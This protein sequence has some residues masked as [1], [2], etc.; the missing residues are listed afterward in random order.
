[1]PRSDTRPPGPAPACEHCG[2]PLRWIGRGR[3][4][5]CPACGWR[6]CRTVGEYAAAEV[7][8]VEREI[9]DAAQR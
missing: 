4:W 9:A 8:R 1:M 6:R 2:H 5:C 3:K 7:A